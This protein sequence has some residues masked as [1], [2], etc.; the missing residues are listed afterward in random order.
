MM[1]WG[2]ASALV[3]GTGLVFFGVYWLAEWQHWRLMRRFDK[4]REEARRRAI[5]ERDR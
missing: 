2:I 4:A 3:A 5:W 1:W